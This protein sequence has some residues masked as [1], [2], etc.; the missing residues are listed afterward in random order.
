MFR[1]VHHWYRSL[2]SCR[3]GGYHAYKPADGWRCEHKAINLRW[4]GRLN[5]KDIT[6]RVIAGMISGVGA[7]V[8]F[9]TML[10]LFGAA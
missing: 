5:M 3:F 1:Q 9:W 4:R 7:G 10:R 2:V 8:A 6:E